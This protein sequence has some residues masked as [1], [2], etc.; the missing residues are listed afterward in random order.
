MSAIA[1]NPKHYFVDEAGDPDTVVAPMMPDPIL[2]A[3]A[4]TANVPLPVLI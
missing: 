3:A 4:A 2:P 1:A